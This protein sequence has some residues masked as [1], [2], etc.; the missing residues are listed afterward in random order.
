MK[1]YLEIG[2]D[3][4]KTKI[5]RAGFL[6]TVLHVFLKD[7]FNIFKVLRMAKSPYVMIEEKMKET[8][9]YA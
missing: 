6:D 9:C 1:L 2:L 7:V 5:S 3:V 4:G 8:P